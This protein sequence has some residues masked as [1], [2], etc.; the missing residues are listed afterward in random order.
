MDSLFYELAQSKAASPAFRSLMQML[1]ARCREYEQLKA[2]NL[3]RLMEA[4]ARREGIS[5][6]QIE[7]EVVAGTAE[8]AL[9]PESLQKLQ[10]FLR[11][12]VEQARSDKALLEMA[13]VLEKPDRVVLMS[14]LRE[15]EQVPENRAV[16]QTELDFLLENKRL[17]EEFGRAN[18][19]LIPPQA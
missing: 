16:F 9:A 18:G 14:R 17:L 2:E 4:R 19:W 6:E 7:R 13:F 8:V 5:V 3:Q 10:G 1:H 15:Y 12:C 11:D